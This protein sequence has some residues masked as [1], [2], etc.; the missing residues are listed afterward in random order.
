MKSQGIKL[1]RLLL[2]S[3]LFVQAFF[4]LAGQNVNAQHTILN[5]N[6]LRMGSGSENSV[7]SSGNLQQPF[8]FNSVS[9]IW[10]K[11]TFSVYPL[12]NAYA[13]NGDKT[14][15]W[16]TNGTIVQNPTLTSQVI[17]T[18]GFTF[19]SGSNGYGTI[20]STGNITIDGS[21]LE[22]ENSFT[23]PQ[24]S[25]YIEVK[26]RVKNVSAA[27]IENVRI[28][29]G[30]RDD[31]V[32][33]SDGPTKHRGNLVDGAFEKITSVAT[34]S[35]ALKIFTADEGILFYTNSE[36]GN[37]IV[38]SCCS[39]QNV[40]N[41]NPQSSNIEASGDGSYGFYVRMN[42]LP[43]GASD[44]FTWYYAAG[45]LADLNEIIGEVA[46]VSG[47]ISD[48]TSSSARFKA[49]SSVAADG[50]WM[51]V[52]RN[53]T[54]PSAAQIKAGVDYGSVV[55]AKSGFSVMDANVEVT[56]E[57]PG[58]NPSTDYDFH[59]VTEDASSAFSD[60][61]STQFST[62]A[63]PTI[64]NIENITVCQDVTSPA[65][66]FTVGDAE[67]AVTSLTISTVS[68]NTTLLPDAN[69]TLGGSGANRTVTV[70]PASGQYGSA[71]ITVTVMDAD[72]DTESSTFTVNVTQNDVQ[73]PIVSDVTYNLGDAAIGLSNQVEGDNLKWYEAAEGGVGTSMDITPNTSLVGLT[74]Y[75]VSQTV[76]GCESDRAKITVSVE[77][78][79]EITGSSQAKSS[80]F[81]LTTVVDDQISISGT[82]NL[83][84]PKVYI[85]SGFQ[86]GDILKYEEALPDGISKAFDTS[87]GIL[88]FTGTASVADWENIFKNIL[89]TTT[90]SNN[91]NRSISFVL[92]D[93]LS[94][95][96]NEQPHYY[97]FIPGN[98]TWSDAKTAAA[99]KV[100]YGM[101]GY[102]AT[103]VSQEENN[104]I[105]EKLSS[106]GWIGGSDDFNHINTATGTSTFAD[107]AAAEGS[108]FWVTGP[109]IG[110]P[111][112]NMNNTP[113]AVNGAYMNWNPGEPNNST[114]EHY[115][116]LYSTQEGRWNDLNASSLLNGYV[117]EFGGYA[118]EPVPTIEHS[119]V[120]TFNVE[121][122]IVLS[123]SA[124]DE[125]NIVAD[126]IGIFTTHGEDAGLTLTYTLVSGTG[127]DG[128]AS[129]TINADTLKAAEVYDYETKNSFSI[130]IRVTDN[131][132]G[133]YEQAFDITINNLN[134]NAPIIAAD[135]SFSIDENSHNQSV[136]GTVAASDP[137]GETTYENWA[138]SSGNTEN[139]FAMN[140]DTGELIIND[141]TALDFEINTRF[142]LTLTV[143]DGENT[144]EPIEVIIDLNNLNDTA[145][146]IAANQSFSLV[147]NSLNGAIVGS[148]SVSDAD[149][150][151]TFEKWT[152]VSG[153]T[154]GAFAI[155]PDKG[156]ITIADSTA[157][158]YEIN[159][160]FN[161]EIVVGDGVNVSETTF[162]TIELSNL[163][164]TAPLVAEQSFE[165]DEN[166]ENGLSV[167]IVAISDAD[168]E[169][170]Y[171]WTIENGN[172][173]DAFSMDQLTGEITV[174]NMEALD[175]EVNA[176]FTLEIAVS[177]GKHAVSQ[178][179][180]INL[181]NLND[182]APEIASGQRYSIDEN[183]VA[184][185][186][187]GTIL[188]SDE[189][190]E[191]DY[192][193]WSIVDGNTN[194][195]FSID[196]DT[197]E[198]FV[199]NTGALDY[200]MAQSFTLKITVGDGE[201]TSE[202]VEVIIDLK[203][204][205][206]IIPVIAL[207][208]SFSIDENTSNGAVAGVVS[209][210]DE[211]GNTSF[212]DWAIVGGNTSGAFEI[213]PLTGE[214]TIA[215]SA[216]IDYETSTTFSLL[217]TVS[218]GLHTSDETEVVINLNNLNDNPPLIASGQ[219]IQVKE[220]SI[221]GTQLGTLS[222]SDLDGP[223]TFSNW[224]IVGGNTGDEFAIDPMTG[225]IT[226]NDDQG[227]NFEGTGTFT[228]TIS[229]SDGTQT[230]EQ[231]VTFRIMNDNDH[232]PTDI[233]LS[234][235]T[236]RES[237]MIGTEVG[238][239]TSIDLD[240]E[241]LHTYSLVSGDGD[242]GNDSFIIEGDRLI[243][244][245]GF[246]FDYE[247]SLTVRIRT[248]DEGG[249]FF[250]K[251]LAIILEADISL[252]LEIPTA[253]SP[254]GDQANDTWEI[255]RLLSYPNSILKVFNSDG[256]EVF[257]NS[258]Y[259]KQWDG[260]YK[261]KDLAF[262]TYYYIVKLNQ[263]DTKGKVFKGT[264][265]IIK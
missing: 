213:N 21:L 225:V 224:A 235:N 210:S 41:Q 130:R 252:D 136:V 184:N 124:I 214:I 56:F 259:T 239:L 220:N 52:P 65:N 10:R 72:G 7:N 226:V 76:N 169:T 174:N 150:V 140:P 170:T 53:A 167:G 163:N 110:A 22:I 70:S 103:V 154:D 33:G 126:S 86:A 244:A 197:G 82:G 255:D 20:V 61:Y 31:W 40:I 23:L 156:E 95:R 102:L 94:F 171:S 17:N 138:I 71:D 161:L 141:S 199:T 9:N 249:L 113:V 198:V 118:G 265:M 223:T 50:Y 29:V 139:V 84:S 219:E 109:E 234:N 189:D 100:F 178:T 8:Y 91:E 201:N 85:A 121:S 147:E 30:T 98:I 99:E 54:A 158:D 217:I 59:F 166:S 168:G 258:G 230:T 127:S 5:N 131:F 180:T 215:N 196:P 145:P 173:G 208:Q 93:G 106:D 251:S 60:V 123:T 27:P 209:A 261:G 194:N 176:S 253:F 73:T 187:V 80:F 83:T 105:K 49:T 67:T 262:G 212:E 257:S 185:S 153:N 24:N 203:N 43:V 190:G 114:N 245:Q 155:D 256:M 66:E 263:A 195:A 51:V 179:I 3:L 222:V 152:I 232:E 16:N 260:T 39:W 128:N 143:G 107:Q 193:Q 248:T 69:I 64:S 175:Y 75:W 227:L 229:V 57:I 79:N 108:F 172:V 129:F 144:S 6:K 133:S 237:V 188:V 81:S 74:D 4:L 181:T 202:A 231:V 242:S 77:F 12:D 68:S 177:D 42:D 45:E 238:T 241:D 119:R 2:I 62:K 148:V 164:D 192:Q 35:A 186:T 200:E 116:Q 160:V 11:L 216:A 14:N 228:L 55:I 47:S 15:E 32:G 137:D 250:E 142:T 246:N 34:R 159:P 88:S 207:D 26:V 204:L 236:I 162:V 38:Q 134:D 13:I 157:V 1:N 122:G 87:T 218:D 191:T 151:T 115:I 36:R 206:D 96:I 58:L 183:M 48:I 28:W 63:L 19:T 89:F 211:D 90:S 165:I 205:N 104:F 135:Q 264:V 112:S 182:N 243:T 149:G 101:P 146:V 120:L 233:L 125:N 46:A 37:T 44:D 254:N 18:S 78:P 132:G 240:G 111:I 247:T 221:N 92:A 117:V 25:A 97:Q